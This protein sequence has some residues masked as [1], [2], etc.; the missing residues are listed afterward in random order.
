MN[1][2]CVIFF[3]AALVAGAAFG[4]DEAEAENS[5]AENAGA[6]AA[7]AAPA[8][9]KEAPKVFSTLPLCRR[10]NGTVEFC[11]PGTETWEAVEEGRFYP[12]GSAFRTVGT[13]SMELA[14]GRECSVLISG[15]AAFGT[16][17]Q[18]LGG[19][20]RTIILRQGTIDVK[21][22]E[23]MPDGYF[24]VTAPGFTAMNLAGE[25]KY[26]HADKGDGFETTVRCVTGTMKIEGRHFLFPKLAAANEFRLRCDRDNLETFLYGTSGD[27]VVEL[28]RGL[29]SRSEVDDQGALK[30]VVVDD[31]LQFHLSPQTRVQINRAVPSIGERMSVT[32]ITFDP[33]C[34][35][36][37]HYAFAE[38]RSEV[39]TGE[40]IR[41]EK[42]DA[43]AIAKKAAEATTEEAA[44]DDD[45]ASGEEKKDESSDSS[46]DNE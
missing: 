24:F 9:K 7:E 17:Q 18:A 22:P 14:F 13:G 34:N 40:L 39:N 5:G 28:D 30:E 23:N 4:D 31:K 12:L 16:R 1:R 11:R 27:Y 32:V 19:V 6:E 33:A 29:I 36:R 43:A 10:A 37:N 42:N 25:S 20:S 41:S 21:L 35:I 38:G 15:D 3:S 45:E 46:G 26:V 8:V 44:A 2:S